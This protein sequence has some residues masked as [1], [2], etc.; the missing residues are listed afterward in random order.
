[1][2]T[3]S[4]FAMATH[5]LTLIAWAGH[6]PLKSEYIACSV[7]T[8]PVV[9]RRILCELAR[10]GLVISQTGAGG[11]SR[12]AR[13]SS[14]ITLLDVYRAVEGRDVFALHRQPP[15]PECP[16][17]MNIEPVLVD[18]LENVGQSVERVL[19]TISIANILNETQPRAVRKRRKPAR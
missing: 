11:G 6:E 12:L 17:G 16:V 5:I 10:A 4:R 18:V 19:A 15:N 13:P 1:M 14:E 2:P 3:S 8:N 9:I 7:N